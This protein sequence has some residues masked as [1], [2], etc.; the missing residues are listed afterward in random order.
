MPAWF[1]LS[2]ICSNGAF[3]FL[4]G[5]HVA[6]NV[7]EG[8]VYGTLVSSLNLGKPLLVAKLSGPFYLTGGVF[9]PEASL[10]EVCV[11][12]LLDWL[13]CGAEPSY[14]KSGAGLR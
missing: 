12:L 9:G 7:F 4:F 6:W 5:L 1:L 3:G 14:R 11:C 8:P 2:P 13:S 10:V